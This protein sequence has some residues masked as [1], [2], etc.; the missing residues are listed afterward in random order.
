MEVSASIL[1]LLYAPL[2]YKKSSYS[3][4]TAFLKMAYELAEEVFVLKKCEIN[5]FSDNG[6]RCITHGIV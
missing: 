5:L 3:G 2:K 4:K 1:Q 6:K